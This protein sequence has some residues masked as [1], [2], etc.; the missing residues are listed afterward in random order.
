MLSPV[1]YRR[2]FDKTI[3]NASNVLKQKIK[4]VGTQKKSSVFSHVV[5]FNDS[6]ESSSV[7]RKF[8]SLVLVAAILHPMFV[9]MTNI[10]VGTPWLDCP[11]DPMKGLLDDVLFAVANYGGEVACEDYFANTNKGVL[12]QSKPIQNVAAITAAVL[13]SMIFEVPMTA[14]IVGTQDTSGKWFSIQRMVDIK[15]KTFRGVHFSVYPKLVLPFYGRE[16]FIYLWALSNDNKHLSKGEQ[17][18]KGFSAGVLSG[19]FNNMALPVM[20]N[21][22][23]T[24][25]T[26]TGG[27]TASSMVLRLGIGLAVRGVY[28]GCFALLY[29]YFSNSN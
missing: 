27:T 28:T 13:G 17:F 14:K 24:L 22:P 11:K 4:C 9:V 5:L 6:V 19:L 21:K 26:F 1:L 3:T 15:A 29:Q 8:A 25:E 20:A 16:A 2:Y 12:S 18:S 7:S 23:L 10:R